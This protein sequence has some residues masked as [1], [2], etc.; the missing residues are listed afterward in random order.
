MGHL[1][2]KDIYR[3]L[4]KKV[5]QLTLRAPWNDAFYEILKKLYTPKEAKIVVSMPYGLSRLSRIAKILK[6]DSAA[7]KPELDSLCE[8]GLVADVWIENAYHYMPSPLAIGIFE[9]TMMRTGKNLDYQGWSHLFHDY[10]MGD[11]AVYDANFNNGIRT[12]LMRTV[13]HE[14]AIPESN[15]VEVLDYE[16]AT[17]IVE[18]SDTFGIGVCSC[19]HEK[20]HIDEKPCD[21]PLETCMSFG[22]AAEYLIR[23]GM[24]KKADKTQALETLSLSKEY[25]LVLN[26]DNVK[27]NV[28]FLCQC[29][30]CCCNVLLGYN[31]HLYEN[32]VVTSSFIAQVDEEQCLGCGKCAKACPINA[33]RMRTVNEPQRKKK[34]A[35]IDESICIGCG[36]CGLKC[37]PGSLSLVKRGQR[38][39]HPETTFHRVILQCLDR[40][41]LQNQIFDNPASITQGVMRGLLGAF[42][43]LS[44]VKKALMS[45]ILRS[46]FL[47]TMETGIA[48]Q[49]KEWLTEL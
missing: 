2:G 6:V 5:D 32:V 18:A 15:H 37:K 29:C 25:G 8:K 23:H 49:K 35:V 26:A 28:T 47:K 17:A 19:R 24:A 31:R 44:P 41:T 48:F 14:S 13:P 21:T 40:G 27:K 12:S 9:F 45:N 42:L 34:K 10:L 39:I 43:K 11:S 1:V 30:G 38:V 16:K 3:K 33:V 4:G 46:S 22:W 20:L 7:L 36:V